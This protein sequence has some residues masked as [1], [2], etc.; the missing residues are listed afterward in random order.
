M[1][2]NQPVDIG[3]LIDESGSVG[4]TN[5]NTSL[6]LVRK[7]VNDFDI[8]NNTV[9][10]SVFAFR[11]FIGNGFYFNCCNDKASIRYE[12]N[13]INFT[14]GGQD[15]EMALIFARNTMFQKLNG[16][17][18]FSH[19][20]LIFCTDGQSSIQDSASLLHQLG[21]IVYAVGV[22]SGVD[23]NQLNQIATNESYVFIVP[24]YSDLVGQ[25]Y[26]DIHSQICI[27]KYLKTLRN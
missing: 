21:V 22:G 18:D 13:N 26:N 20:I 9:K 19:K 15:F 3:F 6:D 2:S 17:R 8:G 25:G 12:I 27:G 24:S 1:C 14:S 10:I 23:R 4:E 7:F 16:A 11:E 5:F